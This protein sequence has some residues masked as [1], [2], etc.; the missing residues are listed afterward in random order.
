MP[1]SKSF[2]AT[3]RLWSIAHLPSGARPDRAMF[4]GHKG[5]TASRADE[6]P[7]VRL[8]PLP[9][10]SQLARSVRRREIRTPELGR[11]VTAY[12]PAGARL[13]DPPE[14]NGSGKRP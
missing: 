1:A 12:P 9:R 14:P 2:A 11:P 13:S 4:P 10:L 3:I 7:Y 8:T 6:P 5:E